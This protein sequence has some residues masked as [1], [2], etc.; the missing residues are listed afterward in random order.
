MQSTN[1]W[2]AVKSNNFRI[3]KEKPPARVSKAAQ[4]NK[5]IKNDCQLFSRLYIGST[6]RF[7]DLNEFFAH[8]NQPFPISISDN[9]HL[10]FGTKSDILS[11]LELL[12]KDVEVGEP[13]NITSYQI[14]GAIIPHFI[15]TTTSKTFADYSTK[16]QSYINNFTGNYKRVDVVWD[17]YKPD[18]LN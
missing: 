14:E 16:V 8:E 6:N 5:M 9:G 12:Y 11:C 15:T 4:K 13:T 17:I 3:F 10:R 1:F 7:A 18:S 2:D